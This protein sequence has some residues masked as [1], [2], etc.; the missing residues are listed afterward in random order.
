[1]SRP[2]Y[3]QKQYAGVNRDFGS[4]PWPWPGLGEFSGGQGWDFF[5][6]YFTEISE[7]ISIILLLVADV[8]SIS[9][10]YCDNT[11]LLHALFDENYFLSQY[12][13]LDALYYDDN[14]LFRIFKNIHCNNLIICNKMIFSNQTKIIYQFKFAAITFKNLITI[15]VVAIFSSSSWLTSINNRKSCYMYEFVIHQNC[16][17]S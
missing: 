15:I 2:G 12:S 4:L 17:I 7:S 5:T 11:I 3:I 8:L 14:T 1:M 9:T 13:V 6:Q 10:L 16:M